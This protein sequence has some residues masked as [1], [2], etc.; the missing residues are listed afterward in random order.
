[1][2]FHIKRVYDEPDSGDG[3]R[4]LV[5]RLWPRGLSKDRAALDLWLKDVAPSPEL[6]TWFGH[7]ADRFAEF[8]ERYTAELDRN[9]AV[10]RLREAA[11]AHPAVT[12]LYGAKDPEV[13]HA[14]VLARFLGGRD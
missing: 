9:P 11:R 6:R 5:D 3:F 10:D 7:R 8:A 13:N 1:M 14:A 4:V 12:L 2:G